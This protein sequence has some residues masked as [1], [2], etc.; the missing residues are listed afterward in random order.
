MTLSIEIGISDKEI[1]IAIPEA[2][3]TFDIIASTTL[4]H[5]Y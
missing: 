2:I 5:T 3:E 1:V 4:F